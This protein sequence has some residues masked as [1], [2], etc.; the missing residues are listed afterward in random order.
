[1]LKNEFYLRDP[2]H[3]RTVDRL[4]ENS[5]GQLVYF[6]T[7]HTHPEKPHASYT[8]TRDW[9]NC[10]L[11]NLDRGF[12]IIIGTERN[13]IYYFNDGKIIRQEFEVHHG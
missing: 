8:D 9:N 3:Q 13:A 1:M 12:F 5:E 6:G 11:R 7:W 2:E 10:K 4:Y